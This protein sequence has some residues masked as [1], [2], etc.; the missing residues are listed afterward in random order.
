MLIHRLF[1]MYHQSRMELTHLRYFGHVAEALSFGRG[2]RLAHVTP[3]A[4]SKAIKN[5]EDEI[6]APLFERT[7]RKVA[8]TDAGRVLLARCR[9]VLAEVEGIRRDLDE[10]R[11]TIGGELRIGA[12]EVF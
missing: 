10:A 11:S 6:G 2:A 12:N 7:T 9:R 5:L 4:I 8:L 1:T 3:P